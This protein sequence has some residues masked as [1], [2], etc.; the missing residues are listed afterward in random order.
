[1]TSKLQTK[2]RQKTNQPKTTK[3]HNP[4]P[5]L[6]SAPKNKSL[7]PS[8]L[9]S[10]TCIYLVPGIQLAASEHDG[11][12]EWDSLCSGCQGAGCRP[13]SLCCGPVTETEESKDAEQHAH[14]SLA[15]QDRSLNR[16]FLPVHGSLW[17][18]FHTNH[19]PSC[20][21]PHHLLFLLIPEGVPL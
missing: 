6:H 8:F 18:C 14:Q 20:V 4:R 12:G 7:H 5:S 3:P 19:L 1:M 17:R 2:N 16:V 15:P 9:S 10:Q 13:T 11:K 21:N